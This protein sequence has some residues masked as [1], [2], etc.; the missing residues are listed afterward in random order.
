LRAFAESLNTGIH[1]GFLVCLDA[2]TG[3]VLWKEDTFIDRTK[4]YSITG[5]PQIAKDKVIIGNS[6]ADKGV[7]GYI[8]AYDS[9]TGKFAWRFFIVPGDPQKPFE[10]EELEMAA[11]TWDI[12]RSRL[13]PLH[14]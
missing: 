8:S 7:R 6:G 12:N 13:Y 9:E 14:G 1:N 10:H 2:A 4:P 5:P 3:T 11:K